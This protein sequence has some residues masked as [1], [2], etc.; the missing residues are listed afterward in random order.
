MGLNNSWCCLFNSSLFA[1]QVVIKCVDCVYATTTKKV[2][3]MCIAKALLYAILQGAGLKLLFQN[4]IWTLAA[5][6]MNC[7]LGF[8]VPFKVP[9]IYIFFST[10]SAHV[11]NYFIFH[12]V[13]LNLSIKKGKFFN[14]SC[15]ASNC[16]DPSIS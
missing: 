9:G 7:M 4:T 8:Y 6:P 14:M 12:F 1:Y 5:S 3:S 13:T 15:D 2:F 16:S 10:D 11:R